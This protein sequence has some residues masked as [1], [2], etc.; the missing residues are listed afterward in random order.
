MLEHLPF[1]AMD[2]SKSFAGRWP[3]DEEATSRQAWI[4][5]VGRAGFDLPII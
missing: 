4:A 2:L 5:E 3:G 1:R